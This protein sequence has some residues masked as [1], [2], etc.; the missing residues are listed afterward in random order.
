MNLLTGILMVGVMAVGFILGMIVEL[1]I[2][3]ETMRKL[4]VQNEKLTLMNEQKKADVVE[5]VNLIDGEDFN[6]ID[7]SQEW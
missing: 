1:T 4:R 3:S 5:V 2:D 7:Y 6:S